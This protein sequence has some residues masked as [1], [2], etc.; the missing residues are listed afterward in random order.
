MKKEVKGLIGLGGVLIACLSVDLNSE[1]TSVAMADIQGGLGLSHDAASWLATLY[2]AGEVVGMTVAAWC[3]VTF[4]F[5]RFALAAIALSF[6]T[7]LAIPFSSDLALLYPLRTLQGLSEGTTVPLLMAISLRVLPPPIRLYGLAA[8]SLTATFYPYLGATVSAL[9]VD[10]LDW[11]FAFFQVVP[12]SALAAVLVWFGIPA[13][14]MKLERLRLF[15]WRGFLLIVLG[16]GSFVVVLTQGDRLDWFNSRAICLLTLLAA[17]AIPLLIINELIHKLPLLKLQMFGR[18]NF[19]FGGIGL[20]LF[21]LI[22]IGALELPLNY[23]VE[24]QGFRPVQAQV[25]TLAFALIQLVM[26]PAMALLLDRPWIDA[27]AVAFIGLSLILIALIGDARVNATWQA[28]QF[29]TWQALYAIGAPM[30]VMPLLMLATNAVVPEEGP[31]AAALINT[32][33][34]LSEATGMWVIQLVMRER[35]ALHS[36]R[37]GDRL[38]LGGQPGVPGGLGQLAQIVQRQVMTLTLADA[39]WVIAAVTVLMMAVVAIL[40]RHSYPPRIALAKH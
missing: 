11:R 20:F 5:Q 16:F 2:T 32:P 3:A 40:P 30:V 18:P 8:Y 14:P 28:A 25:V 21:I 36:D 17:L 22:S 38:G 29:F 39:F 35:G 9:W 31:F 27:R 19:A 6:F 33:R 13:E 1:V 24:V 15:D 34:A 12:L 23:L 10:V 7:S 4:S 26:L 37:I